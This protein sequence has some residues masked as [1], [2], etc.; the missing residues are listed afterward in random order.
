MQAIE[1][2]KTI[3]QALEDLKNGEILFNQLPYN[4]RKNYQLALQAIND[5][6]TMYEFIDIELKKDLHLALIAVKANPMVYKFTDTT[7]RDNLE[8]AQIAVKQRAFNFFYIDDSLKRNKKFVW[9]AIKINPLIYQF[10]TSAE[11]K[12]DL[13]L[14]NYVLNLSPSMFH[15][16]GP[17]IKTNK[18]FIVFCLL[19]IPALFKDISNDLKNNKQFLIENIFTPLLRQFKNTES[20]VIKQQLMEKIYNFKLYL[21]LNIQKDANLQKLFYKAELFLNRY[22]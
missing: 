20:E 19:K 1:Y 16:A 17:V 5:D 11:L 2:N 9:E 22:K 13:K 10:I 15:F 14:A 7:L 4:Y 8:L 3:N 6:S 18:H 21:P 12:N